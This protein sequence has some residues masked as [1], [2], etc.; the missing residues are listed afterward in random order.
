MTRRIVSVIE[1]QRGTFGELGC[2][3]DEAC[4]DFSDANEVFMVSRAAGMAATR[5]EMLNTHR[6]QIKDTVIWNIEEGLK[7]SAADVGIA[8]VKRAA[9]LRESSQVYGD[10]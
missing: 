1:S 2:D 9:S 3:L 7:L 10:L 8:E 4:P 5:A 6:D